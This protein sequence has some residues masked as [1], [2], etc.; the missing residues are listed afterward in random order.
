MDCSPPGSS[1][2][3]ISQARLLEWVAISFSRGSS[4]PRD[5]T[6]V[7]WV[8]RQI[9]YHWGI[10]EALL[11]GLPRLKPSLSRTNIYSEHLF[12]Y[13]TFICLFWLCWIL[14]LACRLSVIGLSC[15]AECGILFPHPEIKPLSPALESQLLTTGP[16]GKS[17]LE[18]L[19]DS[20]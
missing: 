9:L 12:V 7:S 4:R 1:V 8:G 19:V 11:R 14:V 15:P 6:W 3:G 16:R 18:P 17:H 10:R 13:F 5:Q 20:L 2:H